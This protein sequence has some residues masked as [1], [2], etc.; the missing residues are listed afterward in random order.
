MLVSALLLQRQLQTHMETKNDTG[1]A[2]LRLLAGYLVFSRK[3]ED[4]ADGLH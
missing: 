1:D 2:H 3:T 4:A